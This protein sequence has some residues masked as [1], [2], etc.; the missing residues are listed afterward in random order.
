MEF[1]EICI[2]IFVRC[3][4]QLIRCFAAGEKKSNILDYDCISDKTKACV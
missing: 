2:C 4:K 1:I 3:A